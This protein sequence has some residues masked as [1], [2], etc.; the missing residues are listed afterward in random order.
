MHAQFTSC[1]T[2]DNKNNIIEFGSLMQTE[3][4]EMLVLCNTL[5][6]CNP[7]DVFTFSSNPDDSND[8]YDRC[9]K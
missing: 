6:I 1:V 7:K 4:K 2:G 8:S 5:G 3:K 9:I